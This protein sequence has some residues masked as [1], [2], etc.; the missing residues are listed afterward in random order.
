M[1]DSS[2]E[3]AGVAGLTIMTAFEVPNMYSGLLPSL[4][5][6]STFSGGD[7]EKA[8]HTKK[9]IRKGEF[10]ATG[11]SLAIGIGAA[12]LV[13]HPLPFLATAAMCAYLV[14][15]YETALRRGLAEGPSLDMDKPAG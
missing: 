8:A 12:T 2:V 4:F 11:M 3:L 7:A 5:T 10:Q 6:I 13:H 9:W 1:A 14:W 15:Q